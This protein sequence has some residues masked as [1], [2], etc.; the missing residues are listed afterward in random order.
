MLFQL[1]DFPFLFKAHFLILSQARNT[2]R[3]IVASRAFA[4]SPARSATAPSCNAPAKTEKIE[5]KPRKIGGITETYTAY[6]ATEAMYK[7]C[8]R[9]AD[10]K[11]LKAADED[12]EVPKMEDGEDL[13][14]GGGWWHEGTF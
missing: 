8:A 11:I 10:Y 14:V 7:E 2:T 4:T 9:R 3:S 13:G 6:G 12:V 5:V 1:F